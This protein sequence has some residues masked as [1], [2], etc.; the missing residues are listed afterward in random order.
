MINKINIILFIFYYRK[1]HLE[2]VKLTSK[3]FTAW[4]IQPF[5]ISFAHTFLSNTFTKLV[6]IKEEQGEIHVHKPCGNMW[7]APAVTCEEHL[8]VFDLIGA[9]DV[10]GLYGMQLMIYVWCKA[11]RGWNDLLVLIGCSWEFQPAE[12]YWYPSTIQ[13]LSHPVAVWFA[14]SAHVRTVNVWIIQFSINSCM[15]W[16][17]ISLTHGCVRL[18]M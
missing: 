9:G 11:T 5:I 12:T 4:Y 17:C 13:E 14:F 2:S 16:V 6:I 10:P 18:Q 15:W 1:L 3:S 7:R 8:C